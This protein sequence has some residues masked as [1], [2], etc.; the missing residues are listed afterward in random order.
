MND[1]TGFH[2]HDAGL[3][4]L[5]AGTYVLIVYKDNQELAQ[6]PHTIDLQADAKAFRAAYPDL[7]GDFWCDDLWNRGVFEYVAEQAHAYEYEL[8]I[9]SD[10][11][12]N[13]VQLLSGPH[14]SDLS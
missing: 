6:V 12:P 4:T 7:A 13:G 11:C 5:E 1:E 14:D 9:H 8:H 3:K 10:E 2:I